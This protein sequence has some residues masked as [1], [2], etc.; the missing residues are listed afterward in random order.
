MSILAKR[1]SRT[2]AMAWG[3]SLAALI[4]AGDQ[5]SKYVIADIVMQPPRVI[6]VTGFFNLVLTYNTGISF[7]LLGFDLPGKAAILGIFACVVA[8]SL[9]VWLHRQP[10]ALLVWAVGM[11]S[12]GA[13]GNAIDRALRPGV[14][15]FLDFHIAG[16]HWFAFNIADSAIAIGVALLVVETLFAPTEE[17]KEERRTKDRNFREGGS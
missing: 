1:L 17:V 2:R 10:K 4:V 16:F 12:G 3:L 15:D 6:E 8:A 14:V 9:F 13:V 5:L 11:V 7:G